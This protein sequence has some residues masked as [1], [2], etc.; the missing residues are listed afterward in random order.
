[1]IA[2]ANRMY[3][4]YEATALPYIS[5]YNCSSNFIDCN[6]NRF[7]F[8]KAQWLGGAFSDLLFTRI[9]CAP[10]HRLAD[11]VNNRQYA[12]RLDHRDRIDHHRIFLVAFTRARR[13][14]RACLFMALLTFRCMP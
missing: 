10:W 3:L 13:A 9:L 6:C 14:L 1:M 7:C 5:F 8:V 11:Q 12:L 4:L 2:I